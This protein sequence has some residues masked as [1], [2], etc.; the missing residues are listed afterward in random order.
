MDNYQER[1]VRT[2][3]ARTMPRPS[4]FFD[5][6]VTEHCNL[7]CRGCGSMAPIADKEFIDMDEYMRDMDRLSE[8]SGGVV[9]HVNILGG[10]PLLHPEINSILKYARNKFPVG[11]IRLV[12]NGILLL[13]M[14]DSFWKILR[15]YKIHLAPTK[16]PINVDYDAIQKKAEEYGI[17]YSLFGEPE[18][19]GWFHSKIDVHGQ[20]N[21]NHSF[22]HCGNANECGVLSHGKLYPCPRIT[23][24]KFFN[25]KFNQ[26][27]RVTERDY[28][29]IYKDGLTLDDI[30]RFYTHSVPFCRYCNTFKDHE[31]E[32][33]ISNKDITEWT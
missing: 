8:I 5:V 20:R 30:M 14:D 3:M 17:Y 15:D 25:K 32:W 22:M 4:M 21:E 6:E 9:H 2:L 27:L 23:K 7:N 10:E 13:S 26:D 33:G 11:D 1:T 19:T 16:Y 18:R 12:T 29:D 24:I 28:I 31:S